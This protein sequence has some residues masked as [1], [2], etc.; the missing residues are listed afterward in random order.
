MNYF[1]EEQYTEMWDDG[2]YRCK[3]CGQ[4]LFDSDT[5]FKSGTIWPSFRKAREGAITERP[6]HTLHMERIEILCS[7]CNH[8]LGHVF[9]DGK[10]VGDNHPE[11]GMRYCVLSESLLFE[12]EKQKD[13]RPKGTKVKKDTNRG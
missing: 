13:Q 4:V 1:P 3:Q 2:S 9:P 11:A 10:I 6:D 7:K 12:E 8:H 5:K